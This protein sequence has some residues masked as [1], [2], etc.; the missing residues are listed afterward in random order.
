MNITFTLAAA[1]A[2]L[3]VAAFVEAINAVRWRNKRRFWQRLGISIPL[4]ILA[5]AALIAG[6]RHPEV[7][8]FGN[9]GFGPDWECTI[10]RGSASVCLRNR[11]QPPPPAKPP[12]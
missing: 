9:I 8:F 7:N 6:I 2:I 12:I 10:S 3:A 11:P 4:G 1:L 5:G